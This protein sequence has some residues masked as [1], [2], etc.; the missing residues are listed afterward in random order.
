[1]TDTHEAA[2]RAEA[3]RADV[4]AAQSELTLRQA[5]LADLTAWSG[6]QLDA[7]R[8]ASDAT[9]GAA[10]DLES[11]LGQAR[12]G[13]AQLRVRTALVEVARHEAAKHSAAAAVSV[14]VVAQLAQDRLSGSG[15]FGSASNSSQNALIG[16]Q[17]NVPL[18]SGGWR[19]AREDESLRLADKARTETDHQAQQVAL[20]TRAAWLGLTVGA[21]RVHALHDALRATC[22]RLDAT[23]VGREVGERTTLELLNAE[24]DAATAELALQR[25]RTTLL[26][27]RLRLA[28]LAGQ[29]DEALLRQINDQLVASTP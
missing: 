20:Q 23:R 3:V 16:L 9:P 26:L 4:L 6:A 15:D 18:Y 12:Q 10:G 2:A 19:S 1:M 28:A 27:D 17:L 25:A 14:D 11:W 29:L 21:A 7:L 13:N 8:L 22:S 5:A 24:N